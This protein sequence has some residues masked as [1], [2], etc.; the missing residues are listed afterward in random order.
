MASTLKKGK[1]K[2]NFLVVLAPLLGE[3][4]F[5]G[6]G[7]TTERRLAHKEV[8]ESVKKVR[9]KHLTPVLNSGKGKSWTFLKIEGP[10][11]VLPFSRVF[12]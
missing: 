8:T 6:R 10:K 4:F 12:L 11:A 1:K 3:Y 7:R 9:K 2:K 5:Y